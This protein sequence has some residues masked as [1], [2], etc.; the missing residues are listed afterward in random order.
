MLFLKEYQVSIGSKSRIKHWEDSQ[1]L[2]SRKGLGRVWMCSASSVCEPRLNGVKE[3][4]SV[5]R[6][7]C[8]TGRVSP[9]IESG[10]GPAMMRA[11]PV[12]L[13]LHPWLCLM[14]PY[15]SIF[16][17]SGHALFTSLFLVFCP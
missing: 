10:A 16:L 12:S 15:P 8:T 5:L 1:K 7:C 4:M 13:A 11:R 3:V 2:P 9:L 17:D 14:V 6:H